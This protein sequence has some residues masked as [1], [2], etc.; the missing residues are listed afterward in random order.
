MPADKRQL[1]ASLRAAR[2]ALV[3]RVGADGAAA[4]SALFLKA[5]V[6]AGLLSPDGR[7]GEIGPVTVT[8]YIASPGEPDPSK[9]RAAV[10][11]AGG[12][13]LLPIP[14]A[15]RIMDWALDD[16]GYAWSGP[17][18]IQ[19]PTGEV[20]GSGAACLLEQGVDLVLA[21]ALAVDR[22]GSRL[23]Q[24]GGFYDRLLGELANSG[25]RVRVLAMVRSSEVLP[26][27]EV[28]RETH[29]VRVP[30]VLTPEGVVQF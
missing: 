2:S 18:P 23:G 15:G 7:P 28:P 3:D 16:G 11:A 12:Q 8:A 22:S 30:G 5:A 4:E 26:A 17:L 19:V 9:I 10:V 24:G 6:A 1:R 29:D 27:G 25:A 21:P 14:R 13:V 20:L